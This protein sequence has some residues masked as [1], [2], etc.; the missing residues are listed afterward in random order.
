MTA[1]YRVVLNGNCEGQAIVNNLAYRVGVGIDVAGFAVGGAEALAKC[2]KAQVW[3]KWKPCVPTSYTLENITVYPYHGESLEL[4]YQNP[5]TENVLENGS[6]A[7]ATDGPA[8]C[9][10]IKFNLEP[11]ALITNGPKPPKRGYVAVGPIASAAIDNRGMI[12]SSIML[13]DESH[14]KQLSTALAANLESVLPPV[15]FFPIRVKMEKVLGLFKV[16]SFADV[17]G[18]T[19][20][21]KSSFR[22]SR[23]VE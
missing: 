6:N 8:V 23:M 4:M 16:T 14:L 2:V 7:D 22:R 12:E 10:I 20:R 13:S 19:L 17:G 18:A 5:W 3:P 9:A 15:V 1:I 21:R 11:T